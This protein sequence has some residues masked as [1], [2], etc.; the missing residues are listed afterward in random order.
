MADLVEAAIDNRRHLVVQAGTGT[1]KTLAYLVPA[2]SS[3]SRVVVATATKA[4]QDQLAGKDLPFLANALPLDFDWSQ[5]SRAA[6]TTCACSAFASSPRPVTR[7]RD[8]SNWASWRRGRSPISIASPSGWDEHRQATS[9]SWTSPPARRS[10]RAITV[11]SDECPGA[12]RCPMGEPCFAELAR[13]RAAVADVVVVNTYLYGLHVGVRRDDPSRSRRR[14]V[15]RGTRPR[16]H[17]EHDLERAHRPRP[18][19]HPRRCDPAHPRRPRGRSPRSSTLADVLRDVLAPHVGQRLPVPYPDDLQAALLDAR[20]R[21]ERALATLTALDPP[22]DDAKQ[23]KLRA[24]LMTGTAI[25]SIDTALGRAIRRRREPGSTS[26]AAARRARTWRSPRSTSGRCCA[27][28][29]GRGARRSSRAR[30]FR[31]RWCNG[32]ASPDHR[33]RA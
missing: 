24:Q 4:L 30:P 33:R 11:G 9:P 14:R 7:P 10:S 22:L 17:H 2:I 19:R 31:R 13:R 23:K 21:L 28:A 25:E 27:R 3:G 1:G 26:S 16:G 15:R 5:C 29:C 32:P 6:A 20:S 12:S 8:D 18:L